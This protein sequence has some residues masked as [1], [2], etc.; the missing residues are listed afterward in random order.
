[1]WRQVKMRKDYEKKNLCSHDNKKCVG[2]RK[3]SGDEEDPCSRQADMHIYD[4]RYLFEHLQKKLP[5]SPPTSQ[6]ASLLCFCDKDNHLILEPEAVDELAWFPLKTEGGGQWPCL[7]ISLSK[8]MEKDSDHAC[9]FSP[10]LKEKHSDHAL[11]CIV[12]M[13]NQQNSPHTPQHMSFLPEWVSLKVST[14][15]S[16]YPR[17]RQKDLTGYILFPWVFWSLV[18]PTYNFV[19]NS[20]FGSYICEWWWWCRMAAALIP[21]LRL[22]VANCHCFEVWKWAWIRLD[23]ELPFCKFSPSE[24][25]VQ[26]RIVCIYKLRCRSHSYWWLGNNEVSSCQPCSSLWHNCTML[27][28]LKMIIGENLWNNRNNHKSQGAS[29]SSL[30]WSHQSQTWTLLLCLLWCSMDV[31]LMSYQGCWCS[32][33]RET[34]L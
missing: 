31:V 32:S 27:Y 15:M 16:R 4:G 7:L 2:C 11:L 13:L 24:R 22:V 19:W 29:S 33:M 34:N 21:V 1:M 30:L 10:R 17:I 3:N 20:F 5:F 6:P 8:L 25:S 26:G 28:T 9:L 14:N 18:F 12:K 23:T